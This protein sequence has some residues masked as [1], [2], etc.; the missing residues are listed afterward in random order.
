[1]GAIQ[2]YNWGRGGHF[3]LLGVSEGM[4]TRWA[5]IWDSF[6]KI[7]TLGEKFDSMGTKVFPNCMIPRF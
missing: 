1:M 7:P 2:Q 4:E 5:A 3:P 6:K